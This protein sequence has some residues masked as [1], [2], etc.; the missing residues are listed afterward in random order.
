VLEDLQDLSKVG[1]C[2]DADVVLFDLGGVLAVDTWEALYFGRDGIISACGID[3]ALGLSVGRTLWKRHSIAITTEEA[4]WN[5]FR[6][7]TQCDVPEWVVLSR[8][9]ALRPENPQARGTL[10][11]LHASG[12]RLGILS[13][14]TSFWY[15]LQSKS[16]ELDNFV[17][18]ELVFVSYRSGLNK[19]AEGGLIARAAQALM[20]RRTLVVEDR[21]HN[22]ARAAECGFVPIKYQWDWRSAS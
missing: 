12:V 4:Y 11:S 9:A 7:S 3:P 16:L 13:D 2:Y 19:K 5:D 14:N 1:A 17:D 6:A 10:E 15:S 21:D 22:L 8:T 18:P 20:G